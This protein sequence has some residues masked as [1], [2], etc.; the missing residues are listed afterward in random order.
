MKIA[1]YGKY[2]DPAYQKEIQ[3]L[4]DL[5][6]EKNIE[7]LLHNRLKKDLSDYNIKSEYAF[8]SKHS[9][10]SVNIDFLISIGGDG[11]FLDTI[12]LVKD[13]NIP[14]VGINTGR[15]GF[16]SN[17][18]TTEIRET[19][20]ALLNQEYSIEKRALLRLDSD[21]NLYGTD[22][23]ALNEISIMKRDSSS[24]ITIHAELDGKHLNSYWTDGLIISTATGSTAYSLS[25]GGPILMPGSGNFVV[26]PI[27]PHNLNVRPIV[28]NDDAVLTIT[29]EGRAELNLVALDSRS[30]ELKNDEKLTI[31]KADYTI[32]LVQLN[33]HSFLNSLRNKLNW[34][35]DRRNT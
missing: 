21:T 32:S 20:K 15:L 22:N 1:F 30:K 5:L 7:L 3:L 4:F 33:N 29:V 14:I 8:F 27:A 12:L 16:L 2:L 19:V 35:L 9:E 34:G 6:F 18:S 10:L 28:V 23:H 25:C 11:T 13:L 24:M 17:T 26:T 31:Q